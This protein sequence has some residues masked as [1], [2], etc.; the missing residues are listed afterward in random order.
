MCSWNAPQ[1]SHPGSQMEMAAKCLL[2][3]AVALLIASIYFVL[4][5]LR[6][7]DPQLYNLMLCAHTLYI[8][9]RRSQVPSFQVF[10]CFQLIFSLPI[11]VTRWS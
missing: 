5:R 2:N 7:I 8:I 9:L 10:S 4:L 3:D 1:V 11:P 6:I